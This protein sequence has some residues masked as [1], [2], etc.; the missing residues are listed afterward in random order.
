MPNATLSF[1]L[2]EERAEHFDAIHGGDW[3]NVVYELSMFLRN[4]L[5]HGHEYKTADDALEAVK[6]KLWDECNDSHLDPWGG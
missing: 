1:S 4:A 3:R 6:T 5:K 2:P